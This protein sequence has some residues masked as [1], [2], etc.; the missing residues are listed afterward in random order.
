MIDTKLKKT[1]LDEHYELNDADE[2]VKLLESY[3]NS[4]VKSVDELE[5]FIKSLSEIEDFISENLAWRY[6][7]YTCFTHN[8]EYIKNYKDFV[9][10]IQPKLAPIDH[11]L[12]QKVVH[13]EA[14]AKLPPVFT[15]YAKRAAL[16]VKL[17]REENIELDKQQ[18]LLAQ[19]FSAIQGE[20]SIDHNG[21]EL[22]LQQAGKLLKSPDRNLRREIY[23]KVNER[24]LQDSSKLN[25]LLGELI[26]LRQQEASNC[27]F[28]NYRDYKHTELGRFDYSVQDVLQFHE[29]IQEE[30]VPLGKEM[31]KKRKEMLDVD[32]LRPYDLSAN[33]YGEQPLEPFKSGNE[34]V[35]KTI[36]CFGK[37]DPF[38]AD[39]VRHMHHNK[40]LDLESRKGKA[41]GGYNYPLD[42]T[43]YPFIFMNASGTFR[44]LTTMVHEG[45]H[46]I[47]SVLVKDLELNSLKH[48]PSEVA[49]LASMSM[50][51]MSMHYWDVF[52]DNE[53]ELTRAKIEQ[54]ESV[55]SALPWIAVVDKFQ[56]WL[57]TNPGHNQ[58][59]R[60]KA[61][62]NIFHDFESQ[63]VNYAGYEHYRDNMWQKQLHIFEVPFYY[64]EYGIAQLGAIAIWRN[65]T[66]HPKEALAQYKAAL[67]LGYTK[68]IPEIFQTAGIAFNFSKD[69]VKELMNFVWSA[70]NEEIDKYQKLTNSQ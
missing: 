37:L 13:H 1:V 25:N 32:E 4:S 2:L 43:G 30:V 6:I 35:E 14:F 3:I 29:S 49:E 18:S 53:A 8:E 34:L 15:N 5:V 44:D 61:W 48:C 27:D 55:I 23:E 22:T 24:R 62:R 40:L 38:F 46:A 45:G 47:H 33:L 21:Q 58:E 67:S 54:L 11:K 36:E 66:H 68:S 9:S 70:Y 12:K 10:N 17:F 63:L 56:H 69:Y 39:V 41:P 59:E 42:R 7:R 50:E 28:A 51:L 52:F 57:Y 20:M 64:I 60:A 31:A 19:K 65:F 16:S 26:D